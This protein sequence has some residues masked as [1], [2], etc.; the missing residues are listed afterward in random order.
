[1]SRNAATAC[2]WYRTS[3]AGTAG[4]DDPV[5][6]ALAMMS[7]PAGYQLSPAG[8]RPFTSIS[9]PYASYPIDYLSNGGCSNCCVLPRLPCPLCARRL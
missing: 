5:L 9:Y 8:Y 2:R 6:K 3:A 7:N 4:Y 1:M